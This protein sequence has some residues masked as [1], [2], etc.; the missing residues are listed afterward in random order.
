VPLSIQENLLVVIGLKLD[1]LD[2]ETSFELFEHQPVWFEQYWY[3]IYEDRGR[4]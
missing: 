3:L 1:D 4:K 2:Y